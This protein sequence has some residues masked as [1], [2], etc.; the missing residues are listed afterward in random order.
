VKLNP[1]QDERHSLR[2]TVGQVVCATERTD[3]VAVTRASFRETHFSNLNRSVTVLLDRIIHR[4]T[5]A[6]Y[7][8]SL[9]I[10]SITENFLW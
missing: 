10:S 8:V 3:I 2:F 7:T 9:N 6:L 1:S 5:T 4:I